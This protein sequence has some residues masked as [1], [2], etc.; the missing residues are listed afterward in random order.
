MNTASLNLMVKRCIGLLDTTDVS[1]WENE[2]L[3]SIIQRS[4]YGEDTTKLSTKQVEVIERLFNKHF[5]A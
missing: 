1:D 2:F 3:K 4:K 5:S